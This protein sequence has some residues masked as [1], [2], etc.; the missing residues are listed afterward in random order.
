MNR[1]HLRKWATL[2]LIAGLFGTTVSSCV[3]YHGSHG[4]SANK[5]A[6]ALRGH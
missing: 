2:V 6:T 5:S 3:P 4:R 1:Q